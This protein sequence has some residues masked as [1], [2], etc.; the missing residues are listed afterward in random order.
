MRYSGI[1]RKRFLSITTSFLFSTARRVF[2]FSGHC[3]FSKI[4]KIWPNRQKTASMGVHHI[5]G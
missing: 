3:S 1:L 4:P 2:D 5:P